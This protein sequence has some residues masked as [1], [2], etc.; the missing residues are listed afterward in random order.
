MQQRL[1]RTIARGSEHHIAGQVHAQR[2]ILTLR[3][4][5]VISL[6]FCVS[7]MGCERE[8]RAQRRGRP[9]QAA[10]V[11]TK[12]ETRLAAPATP[13]LGEGEREAPSWLRPLDA[14]RLQRDCNEPPLKGYRLGHDFQVGSATFEQSVDG[15]RLILTREPLAYPTD[16]LMLMERVEL[17]LD[18]APRAGMRF[19]L[20]LANQPEARWLFANARRG[21]GV[22]NAAG[23]FQLEIKSWTMAPFQE[24]G[25]SFQIAGSASFLLMLFFSEE[26]EGPAP[27]E[28]WLSGLHERA[29]IRYLGDPRR[30]TRGM[31]N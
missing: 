12:T 24:G 27:R 30:T 20:P 23:G 25:G 7:L 13:S 5:L 31:E 21:E 28:A 29:V 15:W 22:W 10:A 26:G 16:P 18:R 1:K 17:K 4:T 14:D 11:I 8:E 19:S 2:Y 6:S 9:A 3:I